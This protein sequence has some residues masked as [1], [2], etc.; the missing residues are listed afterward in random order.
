[1]TTLQLWVD[2]STPAT[3]GM[4][5]RFPDYLFGGSTYLDGPEPVK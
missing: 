2:E 4:T 1:M 3:S 5:L